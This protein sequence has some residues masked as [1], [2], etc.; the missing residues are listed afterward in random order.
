MR[1]SVLRIQLRRLLE[2]GEGLLHVLR[3][4]SAP[5][6]PAAQ[7]CLVRRQLWRVAP[8]EARGGFGI[9]LGQKSAGDLVGDGVL[10][11]EDAGEVLVE[12]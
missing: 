12:D 5:E 10:D 2:A 8:P 7:I 11:L 6:I 3:A 9:E 4:E 1:R